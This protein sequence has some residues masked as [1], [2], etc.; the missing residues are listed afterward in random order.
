MIPSIAIVG[1]PNVG[2]STLFNRLT[3]TQNAL[4]VDAPGITRDRQFGEGEY[5]GKPFIIVDTGGMIDKPSSVIEEQILA[6]AYQAVEEAD[7]ILFVVDARAGLTPVD[8]FLS[9]QLRRQNKNIVLAVNKVDGMDPMVAQ[10]DFLQLGFEHCVCVAASQ[11]WGMQSLLATLFENIDLDAFEDDPLEFY[12]KPKVAIIGR[13]NAG[14]STLVNRMLGEQRLIVSDVP[15]TTRDSIF[16]KM[17]RFDKDYTLIDTA[18]IRRRKNVTELVEKFS[19]I[20]ALQAIKQANVVLLIFDAREGISVQDLSLIDFTIEAGR[21]LIICANKWDGMSE[22]DKQ[23]VRK[24]LGYRKVCTICTHLL[25]FCIA[26][27][28]R[29]GLIRCNR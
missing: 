25:H 27:N 16:I 7:V 3:G 6:Q 10:S 12:P 2:K 13:P 21:S 15:G 24:E 11:N 22:E 29:W 4:V 19:A 23:N 17:T 28:L 18:G 5:H 9:N 14:K 26:W 8:S 1:R 20:K